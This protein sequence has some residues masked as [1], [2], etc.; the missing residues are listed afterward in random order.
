MQKVLRFLLVLALTIPFTSFSTEHE[1]DHGDHNAPAKEL[2]A[3][4]QREKNLEFV[5]HHTKDSHDFGIF[6]DESE[7]K[8]Y[9][10]PLPVILWTD[11]GLVTFSSAAFNH[12]DSG[13][14]IVEQG[15]Q[16][17]TKHHGKIYQLEE[18]AEKLEFDNEHHPTNAKAILLDFS[19]TK[20]V[21]VTIL[22][23]ILLFFLFRGVAKSYKNGLA[24]SGSAK[25][26]EPIIVFV[27]DE[28][29]IPNIGERHYRKYMPYLLTVFFFIWFLNLAGMTPLGINV[30]GN[31]ALTSA[32]A[33]MTY[34]I[35]TFT[36]KKD[37]WMHIFWMPGVP[38]P[39]KIVLAPIEL[40]GT[41]I[42]PF[43]LMIRLYAN[44][45]AGHLVLGALIAA[46]FYFNAVAAKGAFVGLTFFL[47]LIELLVALLQAYI[48][49][50]LTAL[51]F[52]SAAEEHDHSHAH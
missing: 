33:I 49:T 17:F 6:A 31:I 13:K 25:F 48:F 15:G 1:E 32:L 34:L 14:E 8:H 36:A 7:H 29:A 47:N 40:L 35:T 2:T 44:M 43:A 10:F 9:G 3:D 30:T 22:M 39:M 16:K 26:F 46:V 37:Y 52:G 50:M 27:R 21:F 42:K 41:F 28:I 11:N 24:P 4:E 38:W 19:I 20:N 23:C 12:D 18:G 5:K 45:L 51:Y